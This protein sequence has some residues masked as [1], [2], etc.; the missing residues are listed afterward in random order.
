M[1]GRVSIP[2]RLY[3]YGAGAAS[4]GDRIQ[5]TGSLWRGEGRSNPGGFDFDAWLRRGGV[6]LCA[7]AN[8]VTRREGRPGAGGFFAGLR[9]ACGERLD[10]LFGEQALL[11]RGMLLGDKQDMPEELYDQYR[12]AG[13][14]HLLAVSG[15]HVTCMAAAIAFVLA[16]GLGTSPSSSPWS[17]L[18]LCPVGG[19]ASAVRGDHVRRH[20]LALPGASP[21]T[22]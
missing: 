20:G 21:T 18:M 19:P 6:T 4:P 13:L 2:L 22:A 17:H 8:E 9:G 5:C 11:A 1:G 12:N 15:L 7:T 14:A 10:T 16:P 3:D